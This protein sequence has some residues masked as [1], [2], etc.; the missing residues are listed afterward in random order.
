MT[1]YVILYCGGGGGNIGC[2]TLTMMFVKFKQADVDLV[3][4]I[5]IIFML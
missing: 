5:N 1:R 2:L 4:K 3:V